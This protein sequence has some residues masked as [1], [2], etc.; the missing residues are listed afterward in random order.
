MVQAGS[1]AQHQS[2]QV[3][4][5]LAHDFLLKLE[6]VKIGMIALAIKIIA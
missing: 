5:E 4:V 2:E 3:A 1:A 6:I